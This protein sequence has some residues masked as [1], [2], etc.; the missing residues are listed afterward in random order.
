MVAF[1]G[2]GPIHAAGLADMLGITRIIV[3]PS[4]GVFSAFGLLFADVE[5]HFVQT[6]FKSLSDLDLSEAG[7]ILERLLH[8]G[9]EL[10]GAEGFD[11]RHQ[12]MICQADMKYVGQTSELT[13]GMPSNVFSTRG[14]QVLVDTFQ[15]E[16][17]KTYGYRAD[18]PCQL[19]GIRVIARGISTEPRV[20]TRIELNTGVVD[21]HSQGRKVYFGHADQWIDTPVIGRTSLADGPTEG[22]MIVEEYDS[23][24]VVPPRWRVSQDEMNDIVLERIT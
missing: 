7:G 16:H 21:A 6:Y 22:P 11:T 2:G 18:A 17:E 8:E 9:R 14:V 24:T 23:T 15:E 5:H 19:V 13:V 1:G 3:P 20:P 4:P 12:K 10:L